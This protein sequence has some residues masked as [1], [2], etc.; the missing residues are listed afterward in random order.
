MTT[1]TP[2]P[3]TVRPSL[4]GSGDVGITAAGLPNVL[5]ECF[6][7][8]RSGKERAYDEA[9]ANA[10]LISAAPDLLQAGKHLAV[11]L[12]E[13][14]RIAKVDPAKCQAIADFMAAVA[15]SEGR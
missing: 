10:H 4:D 6:F 9:S 3:W 1:H 7:A 15:K 13:A 12:A 14:Y 2:G 11:K 8:I 5:A